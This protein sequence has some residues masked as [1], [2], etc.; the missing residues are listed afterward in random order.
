MD[1]FPFCACWLSNNLFE[2]DLSSIKNTLWRGEIA[3]YANKIIRKGFVIQSKISLYNTGMIA[4]CA[5]EIM[6]SVF[7]I[8]PK[9]I[10]Y[11]A[12]V[13]AVYAN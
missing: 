3:V 12:D 5:N 10:L 8:H 2:G 6:Q 13:I 7:I 9:I 11:N 1:R 4:V